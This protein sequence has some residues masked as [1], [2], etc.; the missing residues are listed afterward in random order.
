MSKELEE[1]LNDPMFDYITEESVKKFCEVVRDVYP[2]ATKEEQVQYL[3]YWER[4]DTPEIFYNK[5]MAK[6]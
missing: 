3:E 4:E 6:R 2:T 1:V 5:L